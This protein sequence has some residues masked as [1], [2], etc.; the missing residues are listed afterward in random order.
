MILSFAT[1][2]SSPWSARRWKLHW[3]CA[4]HLASAQVK[5]ARQSSHRGSGGNRPRTVQHQ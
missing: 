2:D 4:A 1:F 3:S 5:A